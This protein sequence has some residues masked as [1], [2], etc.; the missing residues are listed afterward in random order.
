MS[1]LSDQ[2]IESLKEA[3]PKK[4]VLRMIFLVLGIVIILIG[5]LFFILGFDFGVILLDMNFSLVIDII[6]ILIGMII[7]SKYFIASYHLRE[8]SIVF[9]RMRDMREPI[10]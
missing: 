3:H 10:D 6:I 8:N 2:E 9:K 4:K 1:L 7:T 5:F